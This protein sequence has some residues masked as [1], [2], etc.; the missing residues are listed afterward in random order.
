MTT[1]A[2]YE[3][4]AQP[5][6][7]TWNLLFDAAGEVRPELAY[8]LADE[9][10]LVLTRDPELF[11]TGAVDEND[12]PLEVVLLKPGATITGRVVDAIDDC[13]ASYLECS[14]E[15]IDFS[16][17]GY[18]PLPN[19]F[20]IGST[21]RPD[22]HLPLRYFGHP[23][24]WLP[25]DVL[26][27]LPDEPLSIYT[28]RICMELVAR[29]VMNAETGDVVDVLVANGLDYRDPELDEML[30]AWRSGE[31]VPELDEL[32]LPDPPDLADNPRGKS[33]SLVAATSLV[34]ELW[35]SYNL[36]ECEDLNGSVAQM[37]EQAESVGVKEATAAFE[38]A[39]KKWVSSRRTPDDGDALRDAAIEF[40]DELFR[41]LDEIWLDLVLI[42][43]LRANRAFQYNGRVSDLET[44]TRRRAFKP[45]RDEHQGVRC[46]DVQTRGRGDRRASWTRAIE[47]DGS[48]EP[49]CD[50]VDA[51]GLRRHLRLPRGREALGRERPRRRLGVRTRR[52]AFGAGALLAGIA[53]LGG[54]TSVR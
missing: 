31:D 41:Y 34:R 10:Q 35:P 51:L 52:S 13:L 16:W 45:Y 54:V 38:A 44:S 53:V 37:L 14:E 12:N 39:G 1:P 33:W 19:A 32:I 48:L 47:I 46:R 40:S 5:Q 2:P 50:S 23:M 30:E 26:R 17:T 6:T 27:P 36:A 25:P 24:F 42:D 18:P 21:P 43:K 11:G 22:P 4:E 7:L 9:H 8:W 20:V 15:G 28:V 3:D 29:G 49:L